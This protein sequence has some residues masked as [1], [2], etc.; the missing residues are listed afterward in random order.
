VKEDVGFC[1][2]KIT[3]AA[4]EH[5]IIKSLHIR[6]RGEKLVPFGIESKELITGIGITSYHNFRAPA[7]RALWLNLWFC[8]L[9][10]HFVPFL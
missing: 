7:F 5:P 10:S 8:R 1:V 6:F 3:T 2:F 9:K 4:N